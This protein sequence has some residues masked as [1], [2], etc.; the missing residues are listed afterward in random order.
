MWEGPHCGPSFLMEDG[1]MWE[2]AQDMRI[3]KAYGGL[4]RSLFMEEHRE[5][6]GV[7]A[8]APIGWGQTISQPSLVLR[9]TLMLLPEPDSRVLEIGTGSGFQTALLSLV[10]GQVYTV[11]R[12]EPLYSRARTRLMKMGYGNISFRLGD[13][14]RG[15]PQEAPFDRILVTAAAREIP[16]ALTEQ[17]GPGGILLIPVG[18]PGLQQ[19]IRLIRSPSGELLREELDLVRFVP[20]VEEED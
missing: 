19:L 12:L 4:D 16:A 11:E 15:W 2:P 6:A 9:M 17:L 18:S 10:C 3:R 8:P 5:L 7:D 13:G 1:T 20:L 14:S